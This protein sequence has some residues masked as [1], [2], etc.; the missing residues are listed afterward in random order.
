MVF[1]AAAEP[2]EWAV[3]GG[4]EFAGID[5]AALGGKARQAFGSG[6]LGLDSLG[7]ST[8]AE[9]AE[10]DH[11]QYET[12]VRRLT[13]LFMERH[14]APDVLSAAAQ[15]RTEAAYAAGLCE[16]KVHTLL[17][18]ERVPSADGIVE[19]FRVIRPARVQDHAK[20]WTIVEE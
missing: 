20:I 5:A 17:A 11:E 14:G 12:V 18:V 15:A 13:A 1:E 9:V 8:L 4:F 16:H 10:I 19:R 6:W 2:G 7:R 3:P